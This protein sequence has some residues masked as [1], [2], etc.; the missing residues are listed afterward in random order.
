MV[1]AGAECGAARARNMTCDCESRPMRMATLLKR[2]KMRMLG[3]YKH[4]SGEFGV[5]LSW[6]EGGLEGTAFDAYGCGRS[7]IGRV[8]VR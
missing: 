3:K 4:L 8:S 5:I 2:W 7:K 1:R 6:G